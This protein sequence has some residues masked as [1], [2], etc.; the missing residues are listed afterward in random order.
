MN[1]L[2]RLLPGAAQASLILKTIQ[3]TQSEESALN[4]VLSM[5]RQLPFLRQ[6]PD[7]IIPSN[8]RDVIG[9]AT[10][11]KAT[12]VSVGLPNGVRRVLDHPAVRSVVSSELAQIIESSPDSASVNS[13]IGKILR[14]ISP[15]SDLERYSSLTELID[16]E[17]LSLF[18]TQ[19]DQQTTTFV[20]QCANCNGMQVVSHD[21][22][23]IECPHCNHLEKVK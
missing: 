3:I 17:F 7:D 4:G 18:L 13:S 5:A 14:H 2:L 19:K 1:P 20:H 12:G 21:I 23:I 22:S 16:G 8:I 9:W 6:I 15:D 11:L 10:N